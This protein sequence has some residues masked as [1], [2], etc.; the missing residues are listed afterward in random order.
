MKKQVADRASQARM[1]NWVSS[2][3]AIAA[4]LALTGCIN[5][6]GGFSG[7]PLDEIDTGSSAPV[8]FALAGPDDVFLT[9]GEQLDIQVEGDEAVLADLRFKL[10]GDT[11]GV[12]RE[13]DWM[14]SKGKAIIRVTMPAPRSHANNRFAFAEIGRAHV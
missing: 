1:R 9:V 5:L 11:L 2:A 3:S 8:E 6:G 7:V 13:S 10:D 12:G 4:S 14:D